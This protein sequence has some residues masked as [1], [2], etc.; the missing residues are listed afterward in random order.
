MNSRILPLSD[1]ANICVARAGR[2][3]G[4]QEGMQRCPA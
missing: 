2:E 4:L 1:L 3:T